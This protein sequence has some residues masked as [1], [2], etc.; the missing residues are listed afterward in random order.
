MADLMHAASNH[1]DS[2]WPDAIRAE[3]EAN[4]NNGCVGTRLL[5]ETDRARV[6]EIRLKPGERIGFHRHVLDYFWTAVTAGKARSR[7]QDGATIETEYHPGETRHASYAAGEYKIHD[8]ENI[9]DSELIFTTVEFLDSANAPLAIP[10][11][12][13]MASQAAAQRP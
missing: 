11:A 10:D 5:S 1:I 6:W 3:F 7:L 12:G 13:R 2:T 9:G 4:R 8:L